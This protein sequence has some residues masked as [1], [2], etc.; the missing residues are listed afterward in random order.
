M[1]P[2]L[3]AFTLALGLVAATPR[4]RAEAQPAATQPPAPK[5]SVAWSDLWPR[6]RLWEYAGTAAVFGAS[7]YV[8]FREPLPAQPKW[9]GRNPVDD[10]IRDWLRG[11]TPADRQRASDFSDRVSLVGT[12]FPYAVDL[13]VVLLAHRSLDVGWQ[14]LMMDLEAAAVAGFINNTSYYLV[15]RGRPSS[16]E[17][18]RDPGYDVL[19]GGS[20]NNASFPSGHTLT[21]ATSAGLVCVHHRYLPLYGATAA[22]RAACVLLTLGTIATATAR[23]ISDRHFASDGL[24]GAAIGFGSGYGLPWLLHYRRGLRREDGPHVALVPLAVP[25]AV[26]LGLAGAL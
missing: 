7:W 11:R 15:G 12:A 14:L 1:A 18:V 21:I 19:C 4:A 6:F 9:L 24:V 5:P 23:V 16:V 3:V 22:D 2:R 8:R 10:A 25:S 20:G 13:P 17:C 26:G